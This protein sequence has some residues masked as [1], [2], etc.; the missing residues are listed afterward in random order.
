MLLKTA[1]KRCTPYKK[2]LYLLQKNVVPTIIIC[3]IHYK[4]TLYLLQKNAVP[5]TKKRCTYY[6]KTLCLLHA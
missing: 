3:Y 5:T 6:K 2:P 4:K 1:K